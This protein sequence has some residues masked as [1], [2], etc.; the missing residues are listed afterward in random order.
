MGFLMISGVI[1]VH[2]FAGTPFNSLQ[3]IKNRK[4]RAS[5]V[6][7]SSASQERMFSWK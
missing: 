7:L 3:Y 2:Q 5:R 6:S 4:G 1:E